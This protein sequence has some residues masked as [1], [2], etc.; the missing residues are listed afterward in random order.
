MTTE[1]L[2]P[3]RPPR[4]IRNLI[5]GLPIGLILTSIVAMFL[6]FEIQERERAR[7]SRPATRKPVDRS[8][9]ASQVQMIG[10]TIGE[11]HAGRPDK[12]K[13][14]ATWI[15][16]TLG[17]ANFGFKVGRQVF[18]AGGIEQHNIVLELTGTSEQR[19]G[20][21]IVVGAH[22]D[23]AAGS[24]GANANGSG[25]AALM[26]LAQS[27]AGSA[28]ARTVRFVFF[29]DGAGPTA[30]GAAFCAEESRRRGEQLVAMLELGSLG[31]YRTEAG[32]QRPLGTGPA[33]LPDK[34]DFVA[35]IASGSGSALADEA[36]AWFR[37]NSTLTCT[38]VRLSD[39]AAAPSGDWRAFAAA[40]FPA[41]L[42]S[43]TGPARSEAHGTAADLP[44]AVDVDRL[45]QA[46]KA[47]EGYLTRLAN[48]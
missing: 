40:G 28:H 29:A 11:R 1:T 15:E 13:S 3:P 14:A 12:L 43:D 48:P 19:W 34:G 36:A 5:L 26:S 4:L 8:E 10:G 18:P 16:G 23:S 2:T 44:A 20:E 41:M 24:P 25:V 27:F 37:E 45:T 46:V 42:F 30:G 17:P 32:T 22:Y 39:A 9:L 47:I 21:V 35:A 6:Y 33:V 38:A 31:C 7:T